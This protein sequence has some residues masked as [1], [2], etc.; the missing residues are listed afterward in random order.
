MDLYFNCKV[1]LNNSSNNFETLVTSG[2]IPE[3][4]NSININIPESNSISKSISM[5][6]YC[7]R[8]A[9]DI[10]TG[11]SEVQD[12]SLEKWLRLPIKYLTVSFTFTDV[13]DML[14]NYILNS[15][16]PINHELEERV[17]ELA[18]LIQNNIE[19][20]VNRFIAFVRCNKGQYWL[21]PLL[22]DKMRLSS[23]IK[24]LS[25]LVSSTNDNWS[26]FIV[27]KPSSFILPLQNDM[28]T[29]VKED[30]QCLEDF[31]KSQSRSNLALELIANAY[32]LLDD[33]Y[34]RSSII[35]ACCA[36]EAAVSIFKDL[37]DFS[38]LERSEFSA[39]IPSENI[40]SQIKHLGFSSTIKILFPIIFTENEVPQEVLCDC[41]RAIEI[42][43]NIVH[44]GTGQRKVSKNHLKRILPSVEFLCK[45]L[46]KP[47]LPISYIDNSTN[48]EFKGGY[49]KMTPTN[50]DYKI[51][52]L[53]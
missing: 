22:F 34:S 9:I 41:C 6:M 27:K 33:N 24:E 12:E 1:R 3:I 36:L 44:N 10:I 31:V 25:T 53:K 39:R 38:W 19:N 7:S 13:E 51:D 45:F 11:L 20:Y 4:S 29:L 14:A 26:E 43:N 30:W 5:K 32:Q 17:I 37:E 16:E 40:E 15:C 42:R 21:K 28:N 8:K 35:E 47:K 2:W 49:L 52:N 23:N 50:G 48:S 46:L 18:F